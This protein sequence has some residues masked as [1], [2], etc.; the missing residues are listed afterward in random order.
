[1][2]R[3]GGTR[4][5]ENGQQQGQQQL[6]AE[7]KEKKVISVAKEAAAVT[8]VTFSGCRHKE[9]APLLPFDPIPLSFSFFS[10]L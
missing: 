7:R 8:A 10:F 6:V 2:L 5:K 4:N 3:K 9:V 1:L